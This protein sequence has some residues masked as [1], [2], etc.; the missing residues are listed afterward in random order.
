MRG[1]VL[2]SHLDFPHIVRHSIQLVKDESS[3]REA[4]LGEGTP[5]CPGAGWSDKTNWALAASLIIHLPSKF[6]KKTSVSRVGDKTHFMYFHLAISDK[7]R[8]SSRTMRSHY[9]ARNETVF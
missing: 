4:G 6:K 2:S 1:Q 5:H 7:K 3:H 8:S 9:V